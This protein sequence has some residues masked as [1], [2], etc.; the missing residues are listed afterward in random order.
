VQGLEIASLIPKKQRALVLQGGG[1]LGA[2][3]AGVIVVL[4]KWISSQIKEGDNIF[5]T[6]VG[7]S[8]GAINGAVLVSHVLENKRRDESLTPLQSWEGSAEKLEQFWTYVKTKNY[9]LDMININFLFFDS[10]RNTSRMMKKNWELLLAE[11]SNDQSIA[12]NYIMK[13]WFSYLKFL[14]EAWDLPASSEAA[15]RYWSVRLPLPSPLFGIP[16]VAAIF[17]RF[18]LKFGDPFS[19]MF[20]GEHERLPFYQHHPPFSLKETLEKYVCFPIK[21]KFD[22]GLNEPRLIAISVD[23]QLGVTVTFDSYPTLKRTQSGYEEEWSAEYGQGNEKHVIP[24]PN[25]IGWKELRTSFSMETLHRYATLRDKVTGKNRTFWD[26]GL[27]SNTPFRELMNQHQKYWIEYIEN[28]LKLKVWDGENG[29]SVPTL[30][31]YIIDLWPNI[32]KG[33]FVPSDNDFVVTWRTNSM[34]RDKTEYE[35]KVAKRMSDYGLIIE[36]L[37][38]S[39]KKAPSDP[40]IKDARR[41][42]LSILSKATD[43]TA[44]SSHRKTYADLLRNNIRIRK[45]LRIQRE[46]DGSESQFAMEDFSD[47]TIRRL[48]EQGKHDALY[49]IIKNLLAALNNL[50]GLPGRTRDS[51]SSLLTVASN[52]LEKEGK[53]LEEVMMLLHKFAS[54]LDELEAD[55]K[56]KDDI[57]VLDKISLLRP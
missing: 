37:L 30:D 42:T 5:D 1:A 52:T 48:F 45:V 17:P 7:T 16:N 47:I 41:T 6:I 9:L 32:L 56:S 53:F 44:Y 2:Y 19:F 27:S 35:E 36:D 28:K 25:G 51:L 40:G 54:S 39:L 11:G 4:C 15:R 8:I 22:K 21:T 24:Y 29:V 14:I 57:S 55:V 38:A 26:G 49:Y 20:R 23:V 43:G 31:V 18:D 50:E 13:E 33:D 12:N 10:A 46:D 34:L 3:E